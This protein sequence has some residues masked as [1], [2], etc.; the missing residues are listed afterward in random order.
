MITYYASIAVSMSDTV[1]SETGNYFKGSVFDITSFREIEK[2]LSG[3]ISVKGTL[4]GFLGSLLIGGLYWFCYGAAISTVLIITMS[5][6]AG[7]LIDSV[8]GSI[9]QSKYINEKGNVTEAKSGAAKLMK[10]F[11]WMSND[12]VNALSNLAVTAILLAMLLLYSV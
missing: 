4:L 8:I 6:F 10:G 1:S 7:M 2:G 5:G 9:F 3:G 12:T 11:H